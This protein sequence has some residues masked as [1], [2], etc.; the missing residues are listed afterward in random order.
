MGLI[1][2]SELLLPIL[3]IPLWKLCKGA[4]FLSVKV[5]SM[6]FAQGELKA[7]HSS[8]VNCHSMGTVNE[9]V[10]SEIACRMTVDD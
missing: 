9:L 10:I 2:A 5:F 3:D 7:G 4:N 8:L 6:P 1:L